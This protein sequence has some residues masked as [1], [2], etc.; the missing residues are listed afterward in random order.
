MRYLP[1]YASIP[2]LFACSGGQPAGAVRPDQGPAA[3]YHPCPK[4][5]GDRHDEDPQ[6]PY[7]LGYVNFCR[8]EANWTRLTDFD[9]SGAVQ[10][11][12]PLSRIWV[13]D[14]ELR[15]ELQGKT[16][17]GKGMEKVEIKANLRNGRDPGLLRVAAVKR[18]EGEIKPD[19]GIRYLYQMEHSADGGHTWTTGLCV[20]AAGRPESLWAIPVAASVDK[21][22]KVTSTPPDAHLVHLSLSCGLGAVAECVSWGYGPGKKPG[23]TFQACIRAAR[24]DYCATGEK[25]DNTCPGTEIEHWSPDEAQGPEKLP[26]E[27]AWGADGVICRD[28]PRWSFLPGG[29]EVPVCHKVEEAQKIAAQKGKTILFYTGSQP[30][31]ANKCPVGLPPGVVDK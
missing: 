18:N 14:G 20:R 26:F 30:H 13:E 9:V 17:V 28:H 5:V 23:A 24:A 7:V 8:T 27:A 4:V 3:S 15:G 29:C 6:S 21:T 22:G 2:L 19:G 25:A 1:L 10:N 31:Q 12:L 16:L 11:K